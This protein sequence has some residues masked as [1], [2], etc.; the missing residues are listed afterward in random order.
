MNED[1]AY[2]ANECPQKEDYDH[3]VEMVEKGEKMRWIPVEE[4]MPEHNDVVLAY[5]PE[6]KGSGCEI[7]IQKGWSVKL[8]FC[9]HWMPLPEPPEVKS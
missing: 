2:C 9:S 8:K 3:I 4:R 5:F 6:M 1:R 7:Q